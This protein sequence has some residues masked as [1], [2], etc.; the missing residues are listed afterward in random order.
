M[1]VSKEVKVELSQRVPIFSLRAI[2]VQ[3]ELH[4]AVFEEQGA[5]SWMI[6][7]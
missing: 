1:G 3:A 6:V 2:D 4:I 7:K 5:G